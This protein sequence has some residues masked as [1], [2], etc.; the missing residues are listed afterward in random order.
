LVA[1]LLAVERGHNIVL[2]DGK[3]AIGTVYFLARPHPRPDDITLAISSVN[4]WAV[5]FVRDGGFAQ[6]VRAVGGPDA[7]GLAFRRLARERWQRY[8]TRRLSWSSLPEGEKVSFSWDQL[9]LMWQVIG[10]LIRGGVP[11]RVVFVDAAFFPRGAGLTGAD[12]PA[13]SLLLSI[14]QVL[15]PYFSGDPDPGADPVDRSI[16]QFL[17]EP[18]YQALDGFAVGAEGLPR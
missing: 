7:A 1:P 8:L 10:R 2:D 6:L 13:T 16:V 15:A 11:A 4:D 17:Y 5:R 9:V 3:A 12:T 18:L 14:R